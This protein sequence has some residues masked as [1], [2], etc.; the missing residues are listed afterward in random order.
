MESLAGRWPAGAGSA[1]LPV[2]G[3]LS[4]ASARCWRSPCALVPGVRALVCDE[5]S[6]GLAPKVVEDLYVFVAGLA[7]SGVTVLVVE[8]FADMALR[9][10]TRASVLVGGTVRL[11]GNPSEVRAGLQ[12]AYLG[13][14]AVAGGVQPPGV[15]RRAGAECRGP[16]QAL[17][18]SGASSTATAS[19]ADPSET[20]RSSAIEPAW[21]RSPTHVGRGDLLGRAPTRQEATGARIPRWRLALRPTDSTEDLAETGPSS[22]GRASRPP[23]LGRRL[24]Q[25][26]LE[27][28]RALVP[29]GPGLLRAVGKKGREAAQ[30]HPEG[31]PEGGTGGSGAS[32]VA[33]AFSI[34]AGLH[35]LDI[36]VAVRP[37]ERL[38]DLQGTSVVVVVQR[39]CGFCHHRCQR[40]QHGGVDRLGDGRRRQIGPGAGTGR[41]WMR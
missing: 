5:L 18:A 9:F 28:N 12:E 30:E 38:D 6:M 3:S 26:R 17:S 32:L 10:A 2:A 24:P 11:A 8:Q 31:R 19:S 34:S 21:A 20:K 29:P 39:V 7:A 40:R 14:P 1:P 25:A 22:S 4:G 16:G 41:T 27:V 13:G 36:V 33:D 15:T 37:E 23:G 35:Q